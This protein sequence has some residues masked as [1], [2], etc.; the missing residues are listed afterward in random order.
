MTKIMHKN[1][2]ENEIQEKTKDN[3]QI[4]KK[5]ILKHTNITSIINIVVK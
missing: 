1:I 2:T 3:I 5:L 4:K